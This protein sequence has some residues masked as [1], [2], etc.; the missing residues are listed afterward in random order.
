MADVAKPYAAV[1]GRFLT[2]WEH[3]AVTVRSHETGLVVE[4]FC[5]GERIA[6]RR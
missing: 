5:T 3:G 4:T 6:V 2:T 1:G